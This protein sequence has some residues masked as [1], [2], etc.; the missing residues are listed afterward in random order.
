MAVLS[1]AHTVD[2]SS[3]PGG[4]NWF[5][6]DGER[7]ETDGPGGKMTFDCY[8][9][10]Q[11]AESAQ[12]TSVRLSF[13]EAVGIDRREK[14]EHNAYPLRCYP[15]GIAVIINNEQ[16]DNMS[17]REGT[18]I[19]EGNLIKTFRYLGYVVWVYRNCTS[20]QMIGIFETMRLRSHHDYDS[21]VCCI[22]THGQEGH[23]YSSDN[24]S[25]KLEDLTTKL[26]ARN[27]ETLA[28]KPKMFFIQ[29]CRGKIKDPAARI[30]CDSPRPRIERDGGGQTL[31]VPNEADFIFSYATPSGQA[32][33]RDL[34]C[35]SWYISELCKVLC[36]SSTF[37]HLDDMLKE[38][39]VSVGKYEYQTYRQVPE[40]VQRLH[41]N[42]YFF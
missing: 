33:F 34:D 13:T 5:P 24:E 22:L 3:T 25:I 14:H 35:G 17:K 36:R 12:S 20:V 11:P 39:H 10:Y 28:G 29:A 40:V 37:L 9:P 15:H 2:K 41:H 19:D 31:D 8:Q 38:V 32:C 27:C 16:F 1:V 42:I 7:I 21:F 30:A 23:I 6:R 4:N 26:S 18:E